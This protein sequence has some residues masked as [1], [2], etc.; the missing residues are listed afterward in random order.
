M[1]SKIN[2]IDIF[3][4]I[5]GLTYGLQK[6]GIKVIAGFDI[7]KS[8]KFAF[9]K[10]N[11]SVFIAKD[12]REMNSDELK[13]LYPPDS[14]KILVGCAPCQPF[15]KLTQKYKNRVKDE[16]WSLL[17][18]FA[19][20][21]EQLHPDIVSMENVPELETQLVFEE[22]VKILKTNNYNVSFK[23]VFCPDYGIPQNRTRLVL[24]ASRFGEIEI[25]KPT[26]KPPKYK[27]VRDTIG[28]FADLKGNQKKDKLHIS[29]KLS[30]KNLQ[31]IL[32]S[33][34]GGTWRDWPKELLSPCHVRNS[35]KTYASVY[36]RMEWDKPS[37]TITTQFFNFGSGRFGH[38]EDNRALTLREGALLQTF[39]KKYKFID[40]E[41]QFSFKKIGTYIGNA[42][43]PRLGYII[44]KSILKHLEEYDVK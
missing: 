41:Q 30:P 27:T 26:H 14:I 12:M 38:P 24:L 36:G 21:I 42:V 4:G 17:K 35:G 2:A 8:C 16:K 7:D 40:I 6:S 1:K 5:G 29:Q 18:Y 10:N 44:G 43:P 32:H 34:Q 28:S 19:N 20:I 39:P 23:L 13:D 15:S 25:I 11:N 37:P 3:C 31:R 22:F 9:E 33:A